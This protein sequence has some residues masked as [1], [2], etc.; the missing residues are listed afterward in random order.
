M[1]LFLYFESVEYTLDFLVTRARLSE[2]EKKTGPAGTVWLGD[3]RAAEQT[4]YFVIQKMVRVAANKADWQAQKDTEQA[5]AAGK[6]S[7]EETWDIVDGPLVPL[8]TKDMPEKVEA[9]RKQLVTEN[10][11]R[12]KT[13]K[14]Y[15]EWDQI[16]ADN[17]RVFDFRGFY[18]DAMRDT[19]MGGLGNVGVIETRLKPDKIRSKFSNYRYDVILHR[20]PDGYLESVEARR[21]K[22]PGIVTKGFHE[23]LDIEQLVKVGI[24]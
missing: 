13:L 18:R 5:I 8:W 2:K 24:H 11:F 6:I 15:T 1:A 22:L 10:Y 9:V 19:S 12:K 23:G 4:K 16:G 21:E 20:F 14:W 3:V 7:M 17:S